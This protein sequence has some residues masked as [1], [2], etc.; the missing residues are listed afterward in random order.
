MMT[1]LEQLE[2]LNA[3][4]LI[5]GNGTFSTLARVVDMKESYGTTRYLV[6]PVIG[7][8]EAWVERPRFVDENDYGKW[9]TLLDIESISNPPIKVRG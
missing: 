9:E 7:Q 2:K 4:V 8:G 1:L 3:L 5:N 6:R